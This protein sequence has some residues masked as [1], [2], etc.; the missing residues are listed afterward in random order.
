[1]MLNPEI[2]KKDGA[3][4]TDTRANGEGD[5]Q[6]LDG[7]NDGERGQSRI[8]EAADENAVHNVVKCLNELCEHH[9]R[10]HFE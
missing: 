3:Y 7:I 2:I 5:H 10:C 1:M 8:R 4:D 9:G 6:K